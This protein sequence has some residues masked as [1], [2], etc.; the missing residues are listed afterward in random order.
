MTKQGWLP[1][2]GESYIMSFL[3]FSPNVYLH[4]ALSSLGECQQVVSPY[5]HSPCDRAPAAAVID[6]TSTAMASRYFSTMQQL[7]LHHPSL[8]LILL[9]TKSLGLYRYQDTAQCDIS[10]GC[11]TVLNELDALLN[12]TLSYKHQRSRPLSTRQ[13][14]VLYLFLSGYSPLQ[15]AARLCIKQ[16][17]AYVH[18]SLGLNK[19]RVNRKHDFAHHRDA[20]LGWLQ[21]EYEP[22]LAVY[23]DDVDKFPITHRPARS[24]FRSKLRIPHPAVAPAR[25]C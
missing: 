17:T 1:L 11:R 19:L 15:I 2:A 18:Y 24:P 9:T 21:R 4:H 10:R 16:K 5:Y 23:A 22:E 20:L 13:A 6:F 25:G 8:P 12:G 7:K 3:F 14:E